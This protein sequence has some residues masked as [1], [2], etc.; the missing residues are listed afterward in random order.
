MARSTVGEGFRDGRGS[1]ERRERELTEALE[2]LRELARGIHPA[3]LTD[4]GLRAAIGALTGRSTV[5]V[6]VD[7]RR[8]P[9]R[10]PPPV[11][12]ARLLRD[13]GGAHQR[14]QV[15]RR[16]R[17][18]RRRRMRR[19]AASGSTVADDGVG[20]ADPAKGSGLRGLTDRVEALGGRLTVRS[21]GA[22]TRVEAWLP[23]AAP[24]AATDVPV[25]A[26]GERRRE[27]V[28]H[29]ERPRRRARRRDRGRGGARGVGGHRAR[30]TT[31]EPGRWRR[32]SS[33]PPR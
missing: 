11:E 31:G 28:L 12:A 17:G 15:R 21:S 20:G 1:L 9:R 32:V 24:A 3:V 2:E 25:G 23:V 30:A 19:R 7:D 10:C 16:R 26:P 13:R 6:A 33:R 22:G 27:A 5:P 29:P 18:R 4:Q 14:D 8:R